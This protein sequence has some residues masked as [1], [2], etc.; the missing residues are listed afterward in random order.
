M[1]SDH[2]VCDKPEQTIAFFVNEWR[3]SQ[4]QDRFLHLDETEHTQHDRTRLR[5]HLV[6]R[7]GQRCNTAHFDL[8]QVLRLRQGEPVG[9]LC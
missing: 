3:E 7:F 8:G 2:A 4:R 6:A 5:G 1:C 9:A